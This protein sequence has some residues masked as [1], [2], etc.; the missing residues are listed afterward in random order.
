MD[1]KPN[2]FPTESNT[3]KKVQVDSDYEKERLK[4]ADEIYTNAST[5]NNMSAIDEMH[6]RT[7]EQL[8]L[9]D[10]QLKMNAVQTENYQKQ[11][12]TANTRP[13]TDTATLAVKATEIVTK[14]IDSPVNIPPSLPPI[15]SNLIAQLGTET[16][17]EYIERISQPHWNMSFDVLPLPSEGKLYKTKKPTVKVAYMTTADENILTSPN[18]LQSGEFLEIL[19][20]RKLLDTNLRYKDLHIGDRN[21]IMLWLRASSYGEMYPVTLLDENDVPFDVEIDLNSLAVKKLNVEPDAEGLF[22]FTLPQNK[23]V[24]KF[25]LLTVGE[26]EEVEKLAEQDK[27]NNIPIDSTPTYA[28]EKQIVEI[29]G[30]RSVDNIK[31]F[32]DTLRL[33]DGKALR[34]YITAVDCGV[35]LELTVGTP[36]GGSIKTFLPLNFKF[37]WPN[38]SI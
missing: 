32:L 31:T 27:L 10:E 35:D 2:V 29:N 30:D 14:N 36:G 28:L 5:A 8:R 37:F 38:I 7:L 3:S 17:D 13:L 22:S 6:Q 16:R 26:M 33:R 1:P 19:I 23:A 20:N 11:F 15:G 34:D 18:L 24:I 21:A 4:V 9:R 25:K 12:A